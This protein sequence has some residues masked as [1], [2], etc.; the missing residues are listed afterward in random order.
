[1]PA[2]QPASEK[3]EQPAVATTTTITTTITN[4]DDHRT[5]IVHQ[6]LNFYMNPQ[7]PPPTPI[8][9]GPVSSAVH[10]RM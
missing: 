10:S 3:S 5:A 8:L 1:M 4:D 2:R 9:S 6:F 7:K